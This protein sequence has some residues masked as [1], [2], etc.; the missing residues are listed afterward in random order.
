MIGKILIF[1]SLSVLLLACSIGENEILRDKSFPITKNLKVIRKNKN[2]KL[3]VGHVIVED[4]VRPGLLYPSEAFPIDYNNDGYKDFVLFGLKSSSSK[5]GQDSPVQIIQN[6]GNGEFIN[7]SNELIKN[8][9]SFHARSFVEIDINSDGYM[10]FLFA[11]HG[12]DRPP[13]K[14][15]NSKV[16]INKYG[17]SFEEVFLFNKAY[18][19]F[20]T[21]GNLFKK[22]SVEVF[23]NNLAYTIDENSSQLISFVKAKESIFDFFKQIFLDDKD[24]SLI[25]LA[26]LTVQNISTTLPEKIKSHLHNYLATKFWDIDND[27]DLDLYLGGNEEK[28]ADNESDIILINE[29]GK[30]SDQYITLPRRF[31]NES[32]GSVD[33]T[34]GDLNNDGLIDI[35]AATHNIGW[36][37]GAIQIFKNIDGKKFTSSKK[38]IISFENEYNFW[39]PWIKLIDFNNDGKLDIVHTLRNGGLQEKSRITSPLKIHLNQGNLQFRDI[40]HELPIDSSFSFNAVESIKF[41]KKK[42]VLFL[43]GYMR[44]YYILENSF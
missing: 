23:I 20:I 21:A 29:G 2:Y 31:E 15:G 8:I 26:G 25:K 12:E 13:F 9:K 7:V 38:M 19:F 36:N 32:W 5:N 28:R 16:I 33:V 24:K 37:K 18:S 43:M 42:N 40:S 4:K 11:D 3:S 35:V 22:D 14:G 27:G 30:F 39:V 44:E 41:D 17:K 34:F 1:I 10:D 6:I